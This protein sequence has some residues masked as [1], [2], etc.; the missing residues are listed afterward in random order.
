MVTDGKIT[1][2]SLLRVIRDSVQIYE[3]KVGTLRR[4]KDD[5]SS[6]QQG[7]ECGL[8]IQGF[9]DLNPGDVIESYEIIEEL[10]TL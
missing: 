8:S 1:R 9:N 4:F 7:Y 3:G 6:V 2:Q 5:V 10:A